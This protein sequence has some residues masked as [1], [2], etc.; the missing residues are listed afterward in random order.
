MRPR[1][2]VESDAGTSGLLVLDVPSRVVRA[3]TVEAQ[4]PVYPVNRDGESGHS[5]L[6]PGETQLLEL[7]GVGGG[8]VSPLRDYSWRDGRLL[9]QGPQVLGDELTLRFAFGTVGRRNAVGVR[10]IIL[11]WGHLSFRSSSSGISGRLALEAR[12]ATGGPPPSRGRF[13]RADP[14]AL[15][16]AP[17]TGALSFPSTPR[18]TRV[19]AVPRWPDYRP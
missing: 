19:R 4:L 7:G 1:R 13:R 16:R 17:R 14:R 15:L 6:I 11:H 2:H 18:G 9:Q 8:E 12:R 5:S 3:S 10:V